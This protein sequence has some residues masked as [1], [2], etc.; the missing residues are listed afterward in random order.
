MIVGGGP[1][2]LEAARIAALRGHRVTL[3]EK[4]AELGGQVNLAAKLPGREEIGEVTGW[5]TRQIAKCGVE[6]H[7]RREVTAEVIDNEAPDVVIL[8]TGA[9]FTRTGS[10]GVIPEPIRGWNQPHVSTPERV[11]RGQDEPGQRVVVVDEEYGCVAP[12]L[13]ELL[14]R[15]GKHVTLVTSQPSIGK[16]LVVTVA[17]PHVLARLAE[18]GVEIVPIHYVKTIEPSSVQLFNV[19]APQLERRLTGIDTVILV[20]TREANDA[21]WTGANGKTKDVHAIGDCV[22][23][24]DIGAAIF[25]GHRLART[26]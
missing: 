21:L 23:P 11:L 22:T 16:D 25:E 19:C 6:V 24:R 2:G 18:A 4:A 8:A 15:R 5:L 17:L 12:G 14:A 3:Y 9:Q 26:L 7:L 10:S 1:S 20:T 13:A